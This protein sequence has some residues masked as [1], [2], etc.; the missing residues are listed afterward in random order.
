M[1]VLNKKNS[2]MCKSKF[3]FLSSISVHE[4]VK[5]TCLLSVFLV[6]VQVPDHLDNHIPNDHHHS[7]HVHYHHHIPHV[8]DQVPHHPVHMPVMIVDQH[9]H[10][11]CL[12]CWYKYAGPSSSGITHVRGKLHLRP[13]TTKYYY[14]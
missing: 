4:S 10:C 8:H 6:N 9:V 13:L 11:L 12:C 14:N 3:I 1:V 5:P 7:S 2:V